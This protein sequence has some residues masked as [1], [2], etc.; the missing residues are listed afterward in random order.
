MRAE[1]QRFLRAPPLTEG[2]GK[3]T[4]PVTVDAELKKVIATGWPARD[5]ELA[6]WLDMAFGQPWAVRLAS[7]P[8][9]PLGIVEDIRDQ[10]LGPIKGVGYQTHVVAELLVTRGLQLQ[11]RGDPAAFVRNL[12]IGLAVVRQ[13][14]HRQ[15]SVMWFWAGYS[16]DVLVRGVKLWLEHLGN[17]PEVLAAGAGIAGRPRKSNRAEA[18]NPPRTD[19]LIALNTVNHPEPWLALNLRRRETDSRTLA[20]LVALAWETPW[21]QARLERLVRLRAN[22]GYHAFPWPQSSISLALSRLPGI[23]RRISAGD[24]SS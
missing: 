18:S 2:M 6:A 16:E 8:E 3:D 13:V 5:L 4:R 22:D 17:R 24:C 7:V 23:P 21:E 9:L 19:Y 1:G 12:A 20:E 14:R 10:T 11:A 15:S